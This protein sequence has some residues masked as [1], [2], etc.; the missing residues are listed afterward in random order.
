MTSPT[1]LPE[2]PVFTIQVSHDECAL[3]QGLV[4]QHTALYL[5]H[6]EQTIMLSLTISAILSDMGFYDNPKDSLSP[7]ME[8]LESLHNEMKSQGLCA[9]HGEPADAPA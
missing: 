6:M 2:E 8:R 5:M 1:N 7:L 4:M 3:L 9:K